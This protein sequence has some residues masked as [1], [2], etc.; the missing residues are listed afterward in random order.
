MKIIFQNINKELKKIGLILN[1]IQEMPFIEIYNK[2][3]DW[4]GG[5]ESGHGY[6]GA[7]EEFY[8]DLNEEFDFLM[9]FITINNLK[10]CI[11]APLHSYKYFEEWSDISKNDIYQILNNILK[12]YHINKQTQCGIDLNPNEN[13][14]ILKRFVEG[15]FRYISTVSF[16][17]PEIKLIV[18]PWHHLNLLFFPLD[19]KNILFIINQII[20]KYDNLV[21]Y[22]GDKRA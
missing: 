22:E 2:N 19:Y 20:G 3:H 4:D 8:S 15:G 21:I 6:D 13:K 5:Y 18:Q 16:F 12:N 17:F 14:V 1:D 10:K 11:L 9:Q 7:R